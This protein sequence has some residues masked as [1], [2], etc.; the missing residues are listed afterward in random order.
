[1]YECFTKYNEHH[2][3]KKGQHSH[4]AQFSPPM[5]KTIPVYT[6]SDLSSR[7]FSYRKLARLN[8]SRYK[9]L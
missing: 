8:Q 9:P 1:M 6:A 3:M 4:A 2:R 7:I 5:K